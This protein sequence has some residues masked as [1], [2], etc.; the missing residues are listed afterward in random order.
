MVGGDGCSDDCVGVLREGA[1]DEE[2]IGSEVY[3]ASAM[4]PKNIARAGIGFRDSASAFVFA[5]PTL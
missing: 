3:R 1:L 2:G 4:E 5:F